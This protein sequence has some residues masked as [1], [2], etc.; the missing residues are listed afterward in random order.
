MRLLLVLLLLLFL[1][2]SRV[3]GAR[4]GVETVRGIFMEELARDVWPELLEHAAEGAFAGDDQAIVDG[5]AQACCLRW[6]IE[7]GDGAGDDVAADVG[8]VG[9]PFSG[10]VVL[11]DVAGGDGI[12][13][14]VVK[15]PWPRRK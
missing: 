4:L 14:S 11:A 13:E 6:V 3:R 1:L 12:E 9:L 2:C 7:I 8:V 5:L 15:V 10:V